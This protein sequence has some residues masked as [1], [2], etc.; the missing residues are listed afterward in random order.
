MK[1]LIK[2][3]MVWLAVIVI[4]F[5]VL[6]G[7]NQYNSSVSDEQNNSVQFLIY[8]SYYVICIILF[9]MFAVSYVNSNMALD[10]ASLYIQDVKNHRVVL[11]FQSKR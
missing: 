5:F 10:E 9:F 8:I 11:P 3:P 1:D 7:N 4:L 6:G 2:N